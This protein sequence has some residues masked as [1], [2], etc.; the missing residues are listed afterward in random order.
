M[1]RGGPVTAMGVAVVI[2]GCS[3]D[4]SQTLAA[5]CARGLAVAGEELNDA[6]VKGFDGTVAWTKAASLLAA[7]KVQ[8]QFDKYPNCVEKVAR[9]RAFLRRSA[10]ADRSQSP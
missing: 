2:F 8:Q 6:K 3:P 4:A 1:L 9:A 10:L 5:K 7:A